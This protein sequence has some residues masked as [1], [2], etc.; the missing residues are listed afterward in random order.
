MVRSPCL[1]SRLPWSALHY[2]R[3]ERAAR[4]RKLTLGYVFESAR[5]QHLAENNTLCGTA[6]RGGPFSP[7]SFQ[8]MLSASYG[9]VAYSITN[10]P[11]WLSGSHSSGTVTTSKTTVTFKV[12]S[13]AA[14]KLAP[15]LPPQH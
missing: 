9:S 7:T 15:K 14:D 1:C 3:R 11:S 8:Y 4:V 6:R 10:L 5:K 2:V 12:N 13:V